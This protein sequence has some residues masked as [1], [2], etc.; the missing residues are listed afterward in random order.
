MTIETVA[1]GMGLVSS[2]A[3]VYQMLKPAL[4]GHDGGFID[5]RST[6]T[7]GSCGTA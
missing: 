2:K 1:F 5:R 7:N 4:S 3:R 6:P